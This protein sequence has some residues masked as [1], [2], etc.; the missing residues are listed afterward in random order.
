MT[1]LEEQSMRHVPSESEAVENYA[2]VVGV[3]P[4]AA[5]EVTDCAV[6]LE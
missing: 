6:V 2:G 4:E 5:C 1:R 3:E